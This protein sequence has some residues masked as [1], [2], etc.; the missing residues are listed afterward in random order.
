MK[1][2]DPHLHLFSLTK[3]RYDW[4]MPENAPH[5]SEKAAIYRDVSEH[6]LRQVS[7]AGYVH[8]EAGFDNARPWREVNW[9]QGS[10]RLPVRFIGGIN[11]LSMDF[12]TQLDALTANSE[13]VGVR[14]ILDERAA[15]LLQ[16]PVVRHRLGVLANRKLIFEAQLSLTDSRAVA[17]LERVLSRYPD[18]K[19]VINHG[20]FPPMSSQGMN[21]Q[22]R[23]WEQ[24]VKRLS[25]YPHVAVK[26]SGWE[27]MSETIDWN[28]VS[29]VISTTLRYFGTNRVMMASNFPLITFRLP[30]TDYWQRIPAHIPQASRDALLYAN[31]SRIY[32]F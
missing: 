19:L 25:V 18:L 2:I 22:M 1:I 30:Y 20:G 32:R 16:L 24:S 11:L 7:L 12:F 23:Q 26:L 27:M 17:Q 14:D 21:Y 28:R 13:V 4:L 29:Q 3:G 10:C 6:E 5:W 9:L 8:I 15:T 31:A